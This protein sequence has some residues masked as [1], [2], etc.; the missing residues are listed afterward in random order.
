MKA[1]FKRKRSIAQLVW[2]YVFFGGMIL[3]I[4]NAAIPYGSYLVNMLILLLAIST[5]I[6]INS[7]HLIVLSDD[8]F[9]LRTLSGKVTIPFASIAA[10]TFPASKLAFFTSIG[11]VQVRSV[12]GR[13]STYYCASF[14]R[15]S[16]AKFLE[17]NMPLY[18]NEFV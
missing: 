10:I 2:F 15:A 9:T 7:R 18:S 3:A 16:A 4:D 14:D 1:V 6:T 17:N 12:N 8:A 11:K 13:I 5:Y